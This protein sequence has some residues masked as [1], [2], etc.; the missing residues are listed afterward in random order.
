MRPF[1]V[2]NSPK[3][4]RETSCD[5]TIEV[6]EPRRLLSTY[7]VAPTGSDAG[8]GTL[9]KPFRTIQH[10]LN[11]AVTPGDTVEVRT[12]TYHQRIAFAHSGSA[13]GGFI[14]LEPYPGAHV[15][16]TGAHAANEDTGFGDNMVQIV[17]QSYVRVIGLVIAHDSG[18]SVKDD[19]TA[20][21]VT[22]SGSN[23]QVLDNQIHDIT[24]KVLHSRDGL[25][26]GYGGSGIQ[27]YGSSLT[28]PYSG[29]VISGNAV[30]DCQPGDDST[31]TV[32]LNGNVDGFEISNNLIH[33]DNNIGICMIGGEPDAFG[34]NAPAPDLPQA[35]NGDCSYNTVYHIHANYGGGYAGAIYVDGAENITISDNLCHNNDLGLEVGAEDAG[36]VAG[37]VVVQNNLIYGNTQAGL[38]FGGYDSTV[39]RVQNCQF[40]NNTLYHNDTLGLGNGEV[41]IQYASNCT[42]ANN[43]VVS[44]NQGLFIDGDVGGENNTVDYNLFWSSKGAN[45]SIFMR[46]GQEFDGFSTYQQGTIWDEHSIF[47]N[48]RLVNARH[49]VFRLTSGSPAIRAGSSTTYA[50]LDFAGVTRT[51]PPDIGAYEYS[52]P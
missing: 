18:V 45:N 35:R 30:Y 43:L 20:I 36:V 19:A 26:I 51:L 11:V 4:H 7:Y 48:P 34:L 13:A 46:G 52:A 6:L 24:G 3:P 41:W 2:S 38:V 44:T 8:A 31:E 32:T 40:V 16:L 33:D 12:G 49:A 1:L 47:V 39:G 23:V 25:N 42:V 50:T 17:N 27:V 14:T 15:L 10:A 22:G 9:A 29:V 37:A 28:Q 21:Y 5:A